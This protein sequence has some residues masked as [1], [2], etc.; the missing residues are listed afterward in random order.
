M[1]PL[2][3]NAT[4]L[5]AWL[6]HQDGVTWLL[7]LVASVSLF[8]I[9]ISYFETVLSSERRGRSTVLLWE[10]LSAQGVQSML[11][12]LQYWIISQLES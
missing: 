11:I 5:E 2:P 9:G 10:V 8:I 6:I 7:F 12:R 4:A 3:N 1:D